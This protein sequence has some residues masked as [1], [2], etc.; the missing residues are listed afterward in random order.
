MHVLS[1]LQGII[2]FIIT[3]GLEI[4]PPQKITLDAI[5]ECGRSIKKFFPKS[6]SD[7]TEPLLEP[8]SKYV[9]LGVDDDTDVLAERNRVLTGSADKAFIYLRN[10]RKVLLRFWIILTVT[11]FFIIIIRS[12]RYPDSD[13]FEFRFMVQKLLFSH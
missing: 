1:F 13:A 4:V 5:H 9:A 7:C 2:Y 3:L 11:Y 6:S 12:S 10:L 8:S